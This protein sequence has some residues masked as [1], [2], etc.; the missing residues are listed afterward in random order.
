MNPKSSFRLFGCKLVF[1]VV[2]GMF[3]GPTAI[4]R[5]ADPQPEQIA[6][7]DINTTQRSPVRLGFGYG[8]YVIN[9]KPYHHFNDPV[10]VE[11]LKNSGA[12]IM[13]FPGGTMGN[14]YDWKNDDFMPD[15]IKQLSP[16]Q[17]VP[18]DRFSSEEDY[19]AMLKK[20]QHYIDEWS[21]KAQ[22]DRDIRGHYGFNE[23][24]ELTQKI[25]ADIS[26]VGNVSLAPNGGDPADRLID[27]LRALKKQGTTVKYLELGNEII[28]PRGAGNSQAIPNRLYD[29]DHYMAVAQKIS[30]EAKMVFPAIKIAI[31]ADDLGN[32]IGGA[33]NQIDLL[34]GRI[35]T[36][37]PNDFYD[38]VV[39]HTYLRCP[40]RST[41][42]PEIRKDRLFAIAKQTVQNTVD[43]MRDVFP[44]KEIWMTETG[45][46]AGMLSDENTLTGRMFTAMLETDYFLGYMDNDDIMRSYLKFFSIA[47]NPPVESPSDGDHPAV[48]SAMYWENESNTIIK[49]PVYYGYAMA[50]GTARDSASKL[51]VKVEGGGGTIFKIPSWVADRDSSGHRIP[52]K[53]STHQIDV[54]VDYLTAHAFLAKDGH[55]IK[56][57]FINKEAKPKRVALAI[58]GREIGATP[59]H[60]TA[61]SG[62][63][64][65]RNTLE[66]PTRI[67]P[68]TSNFAGSDP[69]SIP[70]YSIGVITIDRTMP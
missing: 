31:L 56:V 21:G 50:A 9:A 8:E 62:R 25:N 22:A 39:I 68:I 17:L 45:Y 70:G 18:R 40:D 6:K 32:K 69:V 54:Q 42:A 64:L 1:L 11:A 35:A 55:T 66:Q 48:K 30:R 19:Q 3:A 27:W 26:Y 46:I 61:I 29:L 16:K 36:Q 37:Y 34:C 43:H 53:G 33:C 24:V 38:A 41:E 14:F 67:A 5:A 49:S 59:V 52:G 23:F 10:Y 60:L 15:T 51:G 12:S 44:G 65:D 57:V 13:R 47:S 63:L 58:D 2:I 28:D 20:F 7:M 4:V